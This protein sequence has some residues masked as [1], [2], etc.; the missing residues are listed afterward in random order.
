[1]T[2]EALP[3]SDPVQLTPSNHYHD[4]SLSVVSMRERSCTALLMLYY[5]RRANCL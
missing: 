5:D 3:S 2:N 1:M 4:I